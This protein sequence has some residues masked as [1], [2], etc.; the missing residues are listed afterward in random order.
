MVS[1]SNDWLVENIA[2]RR[3]IFSKSNA[4]PS[5]FLTKQSTQVR[6]SS[7]TELPETMITGTSGLRFFISWATAP[8]SILGIR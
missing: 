6:V 7:G 5:P 1:G 4:G 8:P 3:S 2:S